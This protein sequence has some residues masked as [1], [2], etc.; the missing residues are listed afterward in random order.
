MEQNPQ[1][2]FFESRFRIHFVANYRISSNQ[3]KLGSC[4]ITLFLQKQLALEGRHPSDVKLQSALQHTTSQPG[5]QHTVVN[6]EARQLLSLQISVKE[7]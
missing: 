3:N 5:L 1:K 6:P 2:T 4:R 7:V